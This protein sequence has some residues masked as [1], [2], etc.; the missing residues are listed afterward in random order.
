MNKRT[1][2]LE[3]MQI[4]VRRLCEQK[5]FKLENTYECKAEKVARLHSEVSEYFDAIK[6]GQPKERRGE[7][8]ADILFILL[9]IVEIEQ[10]DLT[11]H[12]LDKLII[13]FGRP[14]KYG[15][16]EEDICGI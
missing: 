10:I 4:M 9:N 11:A 3:E 15:T 12:F 13:N 7:E 6:K 5:G 16:F 14:Y 2:G 8:L 1:V